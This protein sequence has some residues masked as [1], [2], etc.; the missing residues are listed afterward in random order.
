[1]KVRTF[2]FGSIGFIVGALIVLMINCTA[3]A[4]DPYVY[5]AL[6]QANGNLVD[7]PGLWRHEGTPYTADLQDMAW[8]AGLGMRFETGVFV[9][10]GAVDAGSMNIESRFVKDAH[11]DPVK[12]RC[13]KDCHKQS[14]LGLNNAM[15]GGE[16]VIGYQHT[17]F[18]FFKP[19]GKVG[20][21]GFAHE[22]SGTFIPYKKKPLTFDGE[23][24]LGENMRGLILAVS[25]G[26]GLCAPAAMVELCGDVSRYHYV[27]T[28]ANPLTEGLTVGTAYLKI[29]LK[30]WW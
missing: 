24:D 1:M 5:G 12:M 19:Y 18:G 30:G 25:Y 2:V 29:P 13:I 15:I 10:L 7:K 22:H 14:A 20:V 3:H 16:A 28:T 4:A 26:G 8:K 23:Q 11:Y 27:A 21:A 9:E 6:G 17:F